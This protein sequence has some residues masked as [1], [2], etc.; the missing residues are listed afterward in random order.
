VLYSGNFEPYQGVELLVDAAKLVPEA[1]FLFVGGEPE[2]VAQ[3]RERAGHGAADRCIF[4]GKRAPSE[5]PRFLAL[6][7]VL[8]SPRIRGANT[9]FKLYTYLA[10]GKPLVAT[11]ISSHT[12]LLDDGLAFLVEPTAGGLAGGIEQAL[13][14]PAEAAARAGRGRELIEREYSAARHAE[15]VRDAYAAIAAG[16]AAGRPSAPS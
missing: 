12:Q 15:K 7:S 14:A 6:A 8:A 16:L 3:L 4:L 5:L 2:E 13:R 9:P 11:R 1:G 10:S